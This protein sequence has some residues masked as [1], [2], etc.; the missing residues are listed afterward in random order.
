MENRKEHQFIIGTL[1][2]ATKTRWFSEKE[3]NPK[4]VP[5]NATLTDI[6]V[7]EKG[8]VIMSYKL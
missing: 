2:A 5:K 7:E 3:F 6:E 8:Y 4:L 1:G